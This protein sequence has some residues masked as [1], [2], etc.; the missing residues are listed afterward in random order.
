MAEERTLHD[1]ICDV[2]NAHTYEDGGSCDSPVYINVSALATAIEN[3]VEA[4]LKGESPCVATV[5]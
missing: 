3:E 2:I 5:V 1:R 4:Y